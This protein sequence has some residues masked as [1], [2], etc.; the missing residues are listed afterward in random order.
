MD[1]RP[2]PKR[3]EALNGVGKLWLVKVVI[4]HTGGAG[5]RHEVHIPLL[6]TVGRE[7]PV[8]LCAA[9]QDAGG[10]GVKAATHAPESAWTIRVRAE[11][12]AAQ[13]YMPIGAHFT[14][15]I[16]I[17]QVAPLSGFLGGVLHTASSSI[18][19]ATHKDHVDCAILSLNLTASRYAF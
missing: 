14:L 12:S 18:S 1:S 17:P 2:E 5:V 7:P 15:T 3:Y 6:Q 11:A 16:V 9:L 8:P 10:I 19:G 4:K 13:L